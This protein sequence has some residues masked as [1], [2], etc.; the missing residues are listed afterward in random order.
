MVT[1]PWT[2]V[3]LLLVILMEPQPVNGS[4]EPLYQPG[5][6]N[7]KTGEPSKWLPFGFQP[8]NQPQRALVFDVLRKVPSWAG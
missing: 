2:M 4:M 1:T 6:E 7:T 8:Q 3:M 5:A